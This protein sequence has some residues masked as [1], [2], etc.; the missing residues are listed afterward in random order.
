M[1]QTPPRR[2]AALVERGIARWQLR[3][4]A[5]PLAFDPIEASDIWLR[6]MRYMLYSPEGLGQPATVNMCFSVVTGGLQCPSRITALNLR[7]DPSCSFCGYTHAPILS[8][9]RVAWEAR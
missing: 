7:T 9:A 6:H 5:R 3:D 1:L 4:A 2:V 8:Q